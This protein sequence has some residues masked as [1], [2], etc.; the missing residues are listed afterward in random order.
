MSTQAHTVTRNRSKCIPPDQIINSKMLKTGKISK[1]TREKTM[2]IH[3][4]TR[5]DR[6][7]QQ[8]R[9]KDNE[10]VSSKCREKSR[11]TERNIV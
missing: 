7:R 9:P 3:K 10:M 6:T 4:E 8:Y 2:S 11:Q 5:N 1:K